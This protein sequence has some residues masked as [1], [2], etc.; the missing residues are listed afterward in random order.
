MSPLL[1]EAIT[2]AEP[3][4]IALKAESLRQNLNMLHRLEENWLRGENRFNAPGEKLLGAFNNGKLVGICGLNRDPF[5]VHTRAGRIRHFYINEANRG[6][7][8]GQQLLTAVILEA[9]I[10]FDFLNT[11]APESAWRFYGKHGF[12]PVSDDSRVTH[13]LFCSL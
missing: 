1:L 9:G 4:F 11:N 5:S 3:G 12:V 7:G 6:K 2:P 10:W 13:R 8:I